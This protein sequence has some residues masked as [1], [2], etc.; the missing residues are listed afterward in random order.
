MQVES[1]KLYTIWQIIKI[2]RPSDSDNNPPI[3]EDEKRQRFYVNYLPLTNC[4]KK[5]YFSPKA[6]GMELFQSL[7]TYQK[8]FEDVTCYRS[9]SPLA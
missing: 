7:L 6:S 2:E 4:V 9:T 8:G 1:W 5:I 3:D